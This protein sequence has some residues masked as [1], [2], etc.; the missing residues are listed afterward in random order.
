LEGIEL[1]GKDWRAIE[2]HIVTRSCSQIRS[3]AQKYFLKLE[4]E[5]KKPNKI[6]SSLLSS[7]EAKE[8][9]LKPKEVCQF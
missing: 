2:Q 1:F 5:G 3:H 8:K 9:I 6:Q 7:P 4:K